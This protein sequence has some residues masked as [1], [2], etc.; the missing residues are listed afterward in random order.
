MTGEPVRRTPPPDWNRTIADLMAEME[1]GERDG[2]T[3]EEAEWAREF[4]R[5][6]LPPDTVFPADGEVWEAI[7]DVEVLVMRHYAAPV[8]DTNE[9]VLPLG[10]RVR[11]IGSHLPEPII[12]TA[13]PVRYD[14][15][16]ATLVPA[17]VREE[18][19]FTNY[20]LSIKTADFNQNFWRVE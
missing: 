10:E 9:A 15:L 4:E 7:G 8:T 17:D 1:R 19:R 6:L 3:G 16:L 12:I 14:E 2:I 18:P 5:S 11:V 20:S 13:V